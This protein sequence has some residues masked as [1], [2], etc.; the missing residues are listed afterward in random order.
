MHDMSIRI[1]V[2]VPSGAVGGRAK[3][4]GMNSIPVCLMHH[5]RRRSC[6]TLLY[7]SEAERLYFLEAVAAST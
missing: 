3:I 6:L 4:K 1:K 5:L 7:E 2:A